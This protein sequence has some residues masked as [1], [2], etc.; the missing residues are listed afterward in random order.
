MPR[1]R[2]KIL[3]WLKTFNLHDAGHGGVYTIAD[4]ALTPFIFLPPYTKL[5]GA[6]PLGRVLPGTRSSYCMEHIR[7]NFLDDLFTDGW[8]P[9]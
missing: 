4:L 2:K 7:F 1:G 5:E 9:T 3:L 8:T 6:P